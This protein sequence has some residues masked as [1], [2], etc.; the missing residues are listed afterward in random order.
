MNTRIV[1]TSGGKVR[2]APRHVAQALA[3]EACRELVKPRLAREWV[4]LAL[5]ALGLVPGCRAVAEVASLCAALLA[6]DFKAV[7]LGL[8]HALP[9]ELV[10]LGKWA[11]LA[12]K[13]LGKARK[14]M[15]AA[16]VCVSVAN[17]AQVL[18]MA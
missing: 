12:L 5:G 1:S 8:L 14:M 6:R 11:L 4:D 17:R 13:V 7:G 9:L 18:A 10:P 15:K 16:R 2:L 3:E